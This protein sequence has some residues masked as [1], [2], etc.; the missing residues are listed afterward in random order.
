MWKKVERKQS[1]T[2]DWDSDGSVLEGELLEK[3]ENVGSNNSMLYRIRLNDGEEMAVWGSTAL[4]SRMKVIEPGMKI[5]ITYKGKVKSEKTGRTYKDFNL[6]LWEENGE[7]IP[8][9][10]E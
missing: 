9:V 3:E 10:N 8:I 2:W 5:R 1:E 7:I 6:D 4:D